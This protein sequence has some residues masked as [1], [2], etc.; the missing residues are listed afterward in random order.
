MQSVQQ[1]Q[2]ELQVLERQINQLF[3]ELISVWRD[4]DIKK[5][6]AVKMLAARLEEYLLQ[7]G[8]PEEIETIS[9]RITD[10]LKAAGVTNTAHHASDY[11]DE[12]YKRGYAKS[13]IPLQGNILDKIV[14][15]LQQIDVNQLPEDIKKTSFEVFSKFVDNI[16]KD[17][18]QKGYAL[19][20]S[21]NNDFDNFRTQD[22]QRA[23]ISTPKPEP[24]E[25][26]LSDALQQCIDALMELKRDFIEYPPAWKT[27]AKIFSQGWLRFAKIIRW[28]TDDKFSLHPVEW[29]NREN[30]RQFQGKHASAVLDKAETVLCINCSKNLD[31]DPEDYEVMYA[32]YR[33]P[34]GW[35]CIKCRG[36]QGI[37][38]PMTREQL[39]DRNVYI[40]QYAQ[41]VINEL[42]WLIDSLKWFDARKKPHNTAR[43]VILGPDLSK[44][45]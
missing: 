42:P 32:D 19:F 27:E 9:S 25:T 2:Q 11:L 12:K 20:K 34:S 36:T 14:P 17:A 23:I 16:E 8:Q 35:R 28:L 44:R 6:Q 30:Y 1:N 39:G 33:S 5:S 18:Q 31:N 21:N 29:F 24:R 26:E 40:Q 10:K 22:A 15:Q 43:K 3:S 7:C 13:Q 41:D 45:A 37:L 38:R 4:T